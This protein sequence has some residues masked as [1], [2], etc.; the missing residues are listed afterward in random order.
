MWSLYSHTH[1]QTSSNCIW[2][3]CSLNPLFRYASIIHT[4]RQW[5]ISKQRNCHVNLII[6]FFAVEINGS[7]KGCQPE[8]FVLFLP[9]SVPLFNLFL[10]A[11]KAHKE[12]KASTYVTLSYSRLR[13]FSFI[14][15][16]FSLGTLSHYLLH[17]WTGMFCPI[18]DQNPQQQNRFAYT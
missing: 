10:W 14:P 13:C 18:F 11:H 4:Q 15:K 9:L 8:M 16:E 2:L 7:P 6:C 17:V 3:C 12:M 1:S 5:N